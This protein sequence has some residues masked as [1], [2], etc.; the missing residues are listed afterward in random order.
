MTERRDIEY[1]NK[2]TKGLNS[3]KVYRISFYVHYNEVETN[4]G[5]Q[6]TKTYFRKI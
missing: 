3:R 4:K 5:T 6:R 2:A 1:S